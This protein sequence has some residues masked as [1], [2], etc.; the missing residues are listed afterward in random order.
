MPVRAVRIFDSGSKFGHQVFFRVEYAAYAGGKCVGKLALLENIQVW[1]HLQ[2]NSGVFAIIFPQACFPYIRAQ[3]EYIPL[4]SRFK[5]KIGLFGQ[6]T[7]AVG[8]AGNK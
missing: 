3:A 6:R 2:V 4:A 7:S 1:P 5:G 8:E